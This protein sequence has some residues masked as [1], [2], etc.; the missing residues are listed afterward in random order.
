MYTHTEN[1]QIHAYMLT[2]AYMVENYLRNVYSSLKENNIL[3]RVLKIC[4]VCFL[5]L[6]FDKRKYGSLDPNTYSFFSSHF[7]ALFFFNIMFGKVMI[8]IFFF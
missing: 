8:M 1:I 4:R 7:Y 5:K 6:N 3:M 2:L